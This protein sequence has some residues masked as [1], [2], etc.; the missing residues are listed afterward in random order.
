LKRRAL[1]ASVFVFCAAAGQ[2]DDMAALRKRGV[3]RVLAVVTPEEPYFISDRPRGGFDW[4]LLGNFA[5]LQ[6]LKLELVKVEG[7]DGL[8]PAL[9]AGRGDVIVGGFTDTPTRRKQIRFTAETFP[10]RSVV[11]TRKPHA[12]VATLDSLA[13][14][15]IGTLRASFMYEDLLAAGIAAAK[16]DDSIRTGGIPAALR[17]GT[18]TAGVDGIEAALVAKSKDP[19][20][21]IDLFLGR[22]AS[23]AWG[24]RKQDAEL[25]AA[26]DEYIGNVRKTATWNR[27]VV[28][29]FG[30]AAVEI[31]KKARGES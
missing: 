8:I 20:L 16:I 4:E 3:L 6:K 25:H 23:L 24:V 10:T 14:A 9:S 29:H 5:M 22:P 19:E 2:A 11:M 17:A 13:A 12:A 28:R 27:L 30:S 1:L 18:I 26:L 31:L 7:W 21:R 15:R